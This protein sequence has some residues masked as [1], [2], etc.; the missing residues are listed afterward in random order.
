MQKCIATCLCLWTS[1]IFG[2]AV[3]DVLCRQLWPFSANLV[4]Q[5]VVSGAG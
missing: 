3:S 4:I 1:A 2:E 5:Y